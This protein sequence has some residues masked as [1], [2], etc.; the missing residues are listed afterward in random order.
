[1]TESKRNGWIETIDYGDH[2]AVLHHGV[3]EGLLILP[4]VEDNVPDPFGRSTD[5]FGGG[6][7]ESA[8]WNRVIRDLVA[9]GWEP[10]EGEHGEPADAGVTEDGRSVVGLYGTDPLVSQPTIEEQAEALSE[11]HDSKILVIATP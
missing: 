5:P 11:L 6:T 1:M 7:L 8:G 10:S 4:A 3:G 2:K 9:R